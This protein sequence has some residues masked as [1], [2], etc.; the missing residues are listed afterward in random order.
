LIHTQLVVPV[1][2][3]SSATSWVVAVDRYQ[4][5]KV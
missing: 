5:A 1:V 3:T 2:L 4:S